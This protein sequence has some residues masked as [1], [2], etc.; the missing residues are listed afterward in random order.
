MKAP[1]S[2]VLIAVLLL[3]ASSLFAQGTTSTLTGTVTNE[4]QPLPGVTVTISS[5]ALQGTRSSVTNVNGG[6]VFPAIPPGDYTVTFE[7]EGMQTVSKTQHIGL[8]QSGSV[9]ADLKLSKVA[10]AITVTASAPAVLE[11]QEV[12]SNINSNL[13]DELPMGRTLNATTLLAP[14]TTNTGPNNGVVISGAYSYDN[15]FLVNG[16]V[17]NENVRGQSHNLFIEDAIQETTVMTGA[18]SA[19]YG[20]FTGGVVSAI[21]KSG[22]NEFHGSFR[23]SITNP[24]WTAK[25]PYASEA[26]HLDTM[27]DVYEATLGGRIIR[28]RLWFFTAG[29]YYKTDNQAQLGMSDVSYTV[30][31]KERRVE[32]KLTGQIT[33]KHTLVGSYLDIS[34]DQTNNCFVY[35]LELTNLDVSRSLPNDFKVVQYNG[36]LTNS[37]LL[38]ANYSQKHFTFKGSGGDFRDEV[39]G[40]AGYD[41]IVTGGFF[42]APVFCG[43][44]DPEKRDNEDYGAKLSYYL[45]SRALGNHNIVAGYDNFSE[46]RL[47]N[48]YQ[49]GSNYFVN[50]YT[51]PWTRG[52]NGAMQWAYVPGDT[53]EYWPVLEASLGSDLTTE[54]LYANDK[55]DLNSN[56]SFNL[57]VRY[58]RNNAVDSAGHTIADDSNISPRV[59]AIY[60]LKGNGK[61]RVNASYSRYTSKVA[62]TIG[63]STSV[64]GRPA[65]FE[66]DY[67]GDPINLNADGTPGSMTTE[68]VMTQ[69]FNWF[70][71]I[72]GLDATPNYVSIP[73]ATSRF[74]GQL[75]TPYVDEYQVGF[76]TQIG[77]NGF[78]RI[79]YINRNWNRFYTNV[80]DLQ[81]GQTPD[82]NDMSW[83]ENT[84]FFDRKYEAF[85]L[86]TA[87]RAIQRLNLGLNYTYSKTR[88]NSN[89]ETSGS[90]PVTDT[91]QYPEYWQESW[92]NPTGYLNTD[93]RHK[94]RA[95]AAYD[96]PT[97]FGNFNFS[98]LERFDSG[99]PYSLVGTIPIRAYVT[100][101]GY[102]T[103]PSYENYYFSGRGAERWDNITST[104]LGLNYA[105]PIHGVQL[106][107][108]GELINA[109]NESAQ[110]GGDTTILTAR[111]TSSLQTF[112]PFTETPV[113]GVNWRK[114]ANFGNALGPGDFQTPREYRFSAGVRF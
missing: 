82:G 67:T 54:S 74:N 27:N 10:E 23:D 97:A 86:Q 7:M 8:A 2:L 69:I 30:G 71:S 84:D 57:G 38:E 18:I 72:G 76:G 25:T 109:F 77:T 81:T 22:G 19:E 16:A 5:P 92:N 58:D 68:Q 64:A 47:S 28:D 88:G 91:L 65:Y 90:G 114:G 93:Q 42:A 41:G 36:I 37:L 78:A 17:T 95:W 60:D 15:L 80:R 107:L 29:R 35:C 63:N 62:E 20:R 85:Q 98:V 50:I 59:G 103:P 75:Q 40:T 43:V 89:G 113:E 79:D 49:S 99:S 9:N 26:D 14:G 11:T 56:F 48:N 1:R 24:K 101:P 52:A 21:T 70:H 112:N 55:W 96:L 44:C 51:I 3:A 83:I 94:L 53:L 31:D 66:W 6:Y 73:G 110:L 104:D 87:Y 108:Q 34:R 100:N 102:S 111:N 32:A 33:P 45:S 4:G 105:L 12:Q 39:H 106:F 61:Y 46:S 13:V